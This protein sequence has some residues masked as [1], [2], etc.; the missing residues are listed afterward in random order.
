[1]IDHIWLKVSNL[2]ES[3]GFFVKVLAP[4]GYK[5]LVEKPDRVGF[6]QRDEEGCR[7]FWII[8]RPIDKEMSS[9]SC[10]AFRAS[11]KKEVD[12]FYRAAIEAGGVDNG[13][14]GYRSSYHEKYYAAFVLDPN[15]H[16]IEAV[17][18]DI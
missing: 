11:N 9:I 6:G 12:L 7:D 2:E 8:E 14:P 16:N 10:L 4:L 5:L 18:D 1:M 13:A 15:G 17:F 3:K